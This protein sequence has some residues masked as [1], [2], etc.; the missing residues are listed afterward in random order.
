MFQKSKIRQD[1]EQAYKENNEA[2]MQKLLAENPWLLAEWESKMDGSSTPDQQVI[3][4]AVGVMEDELGNA[5]PLDEILFS[6]RVDFKLKKDDA[7][8]TKVLQEAESVGYCKKVQSG[9]Q[10]TPQGGKICDTY[11]NSHAV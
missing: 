2:V 5:V 11:L 4:A 1:F 8:V 9:W 7:Q 3:L 10:L 6:L